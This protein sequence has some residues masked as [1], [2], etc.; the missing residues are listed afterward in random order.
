M[1]LKIIGGI[2]KGRNLLA[3]PETTTRPTQGML[4][5]AVFNICQHKIEGAHFLDLCAGSG[6][7]GIEAVSR[8]AASATL[9]EKDPKAAAII[10]KNIEKLSLGSKISLIQCDVLRALKKL[11]T[12]FDIIYLDPPYAISAICFI[13][14]ILEQK[15]LAPSGTLFLEEKHQKNKETSPSFP[16]LHSIGCRRIGSAL[17]HQYEAFH[18]SL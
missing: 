6:A 1:S 7:M 11:N 14:A 8:G 15:L 4:R 3:P 17:L 18:V 13:E 10:R 9:V 2:F 16:S 5:G 12:P